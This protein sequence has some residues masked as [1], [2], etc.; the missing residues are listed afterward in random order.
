MNQPRDRAGAH[1][2]GRD[3]AAVAGEPGPDPGPQRRRGRGDDRGR[4]RGG[5]G[6]VEPA[7]DQIPQPG[8][9]RLGVV[10]RQLE[11]AAHQLAELADRGD[12]GARLGA[13]VGGRGLAVGGEH[14]I[15]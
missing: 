2:P 8:Q 10:G 12:G 4:G 11:A 13:E 9:P 7:L 5:L 15:E 3:V 6:D 14:G 1:Q